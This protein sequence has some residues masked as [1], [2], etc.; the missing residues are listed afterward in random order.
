MI[1]F[2]LLIE[3]KTML[4]MWKNTKIPNLFRGD[5]KKREEREKIKNG[6]ISNTNSSVL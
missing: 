4:T 1:K 3:N 2:E 5:E 6:E